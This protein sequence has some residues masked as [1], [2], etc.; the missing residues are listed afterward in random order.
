MSILVCGGA[1]YIGSHT[2]LTLKRSGYDV[3]VC[4]S[5]VTGHEKALPKEVKLYKGDIKDS[6]LMDKIFTENSIDAVVDFAAFSIVGESVLNPHKYFENNVY[7][8][9]CL[10]NSM[11]KHNVLKMVFSSTAA[12]YGEPENIP[13]SENDKT[14]PENPYGESKLMVEKILKWFDAAYGFKYIAL[15]YFNAAGADVSGEIGEDH[16]PETHLIPIVLMAALGIREEISVFGTD[17][18]TK[19]GSCVRDYIHVLDLAKA[20]VLALES[21]IKSGGSNVY[22]LG[23]GKGFSV[24]EVI[25]TARKVTGKKIISKEAKRRTGDPSVLIAS[26][27]KITKELGFKAE[28]AS[29]EKIIE[30][31]WLWHS[32]HPQGYN[33]KK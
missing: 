12:T 28:Y 9:L 25:E 22:N 14:I 33:D 24:L 2:V 5:L 18:P 20:H 27:E 26:S 7:G 4:D 13:I 23:N 15:R 11:V 31:A 30:T 3:V 10:L 8:T 16:S 6:C 29:L 17:Y 32:S 1:G 21:L 19:D